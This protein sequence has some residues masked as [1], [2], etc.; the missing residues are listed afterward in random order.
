MAELK[1]VLAPL[2]GEVWAVA[3]DETWRLRGEE[4]PEPKVMVEGCWASR[5]IDPPKYEIAPV[6]LVRHDD[7]GMSVWA[8]DS[9]QDLCFN[10]DF[11]RPLPES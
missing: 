2:T 10:P 5:F 9:G 8:N 7:K 11:W 1:K 6:S 4:W 3:P